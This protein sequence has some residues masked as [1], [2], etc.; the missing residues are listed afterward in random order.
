MKYIMVEY[1]F[2]GKEHGI[3]LVPH[4]NSKETQKS[5]LRT[6]KS[7]KETVKKMVKDGK[8][9]PKYMTLYLRKREA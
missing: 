4:G 6:E 2:T 1:S 3:D 9:L 8:N 5:F 7:I